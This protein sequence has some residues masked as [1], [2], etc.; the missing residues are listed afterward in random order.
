MQ[1]EIGFRVSKWLSADEKTGIEA[2]ALDWLI[3]GQTEFPC[4]PQQMQ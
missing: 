3:G 2:K 4:L 1:W